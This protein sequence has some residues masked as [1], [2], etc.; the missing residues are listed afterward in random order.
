MNLQAILQ[1]VWATSSENLNFL[2]DQ[3]RLYP[4]SILTETS[5]NYKYVTIAYLA[6]IILESENKSR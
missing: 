1:G 5:L 6:S 3:V 2:F 4:D